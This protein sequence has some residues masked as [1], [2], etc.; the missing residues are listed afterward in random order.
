M[1][2]ANKAADDLIRAMENPVKADDMLKQENED[3][4]ECKTSIVWENKFALVKAW[5]V[6]HNVKFEE[7]INSVGRR[8]IYYDLTMDEL[9]EMIDWL[10]AHGDEKFDTTIQI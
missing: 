4:Y 1:K 9:A 10:D 5:L 7:K 8:E 2:E 6:D 3:V